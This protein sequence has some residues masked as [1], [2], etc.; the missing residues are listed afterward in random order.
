MKRVLLMSAGDAVLGAAAPPDRLRWRHRHSLKLRFLAVTLILLSAVASVVSWRLLVELERHL[1][2]NL[3]TRVQGLANSLA[4]SSS[5]DLLSGNRAGLEGLLRSAQV[6]EAILHAC[7]SSLDGEIEC[8]VGDPEPIR[9]EAVPGSDQES[10]PPREQGEPAGDGTFEVYRPIVVMTIDPS[11]PVDDS[12]L[13]EGVPADSEIEHRVAGWVHL[14]ASAWTVRQ[15]MA[16]VRRALVSLA[17]PLV[18]VSVIIIVL[19]L[20]QTVIV[21]LGALREG[22]RRVARGELHTRVPLRSRNEIGELTEAFNEMVRQVES[23]KHELTT[24]AQELAAKSEALHQTS[25]LLESIIR[26]STDHAILGADSN[27]RIVLLSEGALR[28]FRRKPEEMLGQPIAE[29]IPSLD[30]IRLPAAASDCSENELETE[31]ARSTGERFPLHVSCNRR[32]DRE[33]ELVGYS[34]VARD[35]TRDKVEE[36]LRLRN[37]ELERTARLKSE[38]LARMSHELRTPLNAII[39]FSQ[40]LQDGILGPLNAEQDE[41]LTNINDSGN[42]LLSLINTILDLSKVEAGKAE[43]NVTD[44]ALAPLIESCVRI[45]KPLA[46]KKEI[47]LRAEL[48]PTLGVIRSDERHLR[49]SLLNLL[50]NAVKFTDRRGYVTVSARRET[51]H[52][53]LCV[54][55]TGIGILPSDFAKIFESFQQLENPLSRE[56]EGSGL[57]L[58]I[59]FAFAGLLCGRVWVES[60]LGQGSAFTLALP[61]DI[62][63]PSICTPII[64][65]T[66]YDPSTATPRAAQDLTPAI[67]TGHL[68]VTP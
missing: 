7:I 10:P 3:E 66:A 47:V 5:L 39:G 36:E 32:T 57:G 40:I 25:E 2:R 60:E 61:L 18:I 45:T 46:D 63:D 28:I 62:A 23:S 19:V 15:G 58:A 55:D 26:S 59:V 29:L 52:V 13:L 34:L 53:E 9:S 33:G 42:L 51:G 8:W 20:W 56:H 48:P 65:V 44:L 64:P 27:C 54:R 21:P 67:P 38:F 37:Q 14:I 16:G 12:A 30:A 4:A 49:Q 68:G 17:I 35:I 31:G 24:R 41:Y 43:L 6:D 50:S 11:A 1:H 22:A